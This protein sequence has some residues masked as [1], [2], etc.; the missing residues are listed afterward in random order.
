MSVVIML[1]IVSQKCQTLTFNMNGSAEC[2]DYAQTSSALT[3]CVDKYTISSQS[4]QTIFQNLH[5]EPLSHFWK[6]G[7]D[8]VMMVASTQDR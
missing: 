1:W 5:P 7:E 3:V 6:Q 8:S 4:G 2:Q